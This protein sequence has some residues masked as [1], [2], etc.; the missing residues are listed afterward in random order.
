MSVVKGQDNTL[1]PVCNW[2]VFFWF[3]ISEMTIP[4]KQEHLK[5]DLDKSKVKVMG[6]VKSQGH[7]VHPESNQ[8]RSFSFH[9]NRTNHFWHMSN[10]AWPRKNT[11]EI[12]KENL[13]KRSFQQEFFQSVIKITERSSSTFSQ[14]YTCLSQISKVYLQRL[15]RKKQRSSRWTQTRRRKQNENIKSPQT[16]VT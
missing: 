14:T 11:S 16:G 9:N 15:R 2:L 6:E 1:S 3:H 7:I 10:S 5:V 13:S 8:C 12:C 4:E